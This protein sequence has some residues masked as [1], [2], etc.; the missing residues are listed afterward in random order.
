[1]QRALAERGATRIEVAMPFRIRGSV[2]E[3]ES[4]RPLEGLV[5]RAYDEDIL[6]D[7]F[8]GEART[9]ANGRF[10]VI[11]TEVQFMDLYETRPDLYLRVFDTS[12]AKLLRSTEDHVRSNAELTE[13]FEVRIPQARL[14]ES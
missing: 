3:D 9:D 2:V 4:G 6:V 14:S 10:E 12:G 13:A 8:L 5:V 11:F 1:V 7:D